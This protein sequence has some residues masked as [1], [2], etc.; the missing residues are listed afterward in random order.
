MDYNDLPERRISQR[1]DDDTPQIFRTLRNIDLN[2]LTIFEAVYV[3]KGI[4]NAAKI[5]NLTPSAI[6]QS[7]QKLRT[8]FPDP[9]F[10][11]KGQ[12]VTP[13][14]YATHLH[15]YISQGLES[16]L[17]A[18]DLSGSYDKQRTITIGTPPSLGAMLMPP[19][20]KAVKESY[21]HLLLR[22]TPVIDAATQLS[23]FQTDLI[24]DSHVHSVRSLAHHVLYTD[25]LVLVCRKGHP[26]LQAP[27]TLPDLEQFQHTLLMLE[28]QGHSDLRKRI[29]DMFPER[30]VSF[31]SYN[32]FTI[33]ALI[34]GSDLLGLMPKRFFDLFSQCWPLQTLDFSPVNE[35]CI[36]F[37]LHYNKLSLRDPVIEGVVE[38]IRQAL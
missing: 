15:D 31:S 8:I 25:P 22:N 18:L 12:G 33:A 10:I 24:I 3:H 20:Y 26:A 21:P 6:S 23:Q 34:A 32:M 2:L 27:L 38:V 1:L 37:S 14:A 7:I 36:E 4:V 5:L 35:E 29:H 17:G 11:R 19:I 30:Q 13:T 16:I 9:L 28:G